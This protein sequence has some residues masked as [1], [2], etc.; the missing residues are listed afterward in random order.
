ML[1]I[2]PMLDESQAV[3]VTVESRE[4]AVE[5]CKFIM[6]HYPEFCRSWDDH[7]KTWRKASA[8]AYTLNFSK[9]RWDE[10][11]ILQHAPGDWFA[12]NEVI[13]IPFSSLKT[14]DIDEISESDFLDMLS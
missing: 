2:S 10:D 5:L 4:E 1:D 11:Y 6:R 12:R 13:L 3:A 8:N 9:V 7:H 14:S